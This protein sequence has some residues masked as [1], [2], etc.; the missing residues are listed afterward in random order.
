M[1][2]SIKTKILISLVV[3]SIIL[4]FI[5][6][7]IIRTTATDSVLEIVGGYSTELVRARAAQLGE[8]LLSRQ[9]NAETLAA[10]SDVRTVDWWTM[11]TGLEDELSRKS[12]IYETIFVVRADG[13]A[14]GTEDFLA[15]LED[16]EYFKHI[17]TEKNEKFISNPIESRA[18]GNNVFV[19]AH[20]IKSYTDQI[21]GLI[22]I[23]VKLDAINNV[24]SNIDL[25][26]NSQA[27]VADGT[28]L[29]I[30]HVD[31]SLSMKLNLL[32]SDE[33]GFKGLSEVGRKMLNGESEIAEFF[34]PEGEEYFLIYT[35]IPN[36][37]NWVLGVQIPKAHLMS[38]SNDLTTI[39]TIVTL[40]VLAVMV[41][42]S[43]LIGNSVVKPIKYLS[44]Q[45]NQFGTGDFTVKF[46]SKSKDEIGQMVLALSEMSTKLR[47]SFNVVKNSML[48]L[49][50]SSDELSKLAGDSKKQSDIISKNANTIDGDIQTTASAIEE[51]TSSIEE[52]A[53]SAQNVSKLAQDLTEKAHAVKLSSEEGQMSVNSV[54]DVINQTQTQT[55]ETAKIVSS[56]KSKSENIGK[57]V[58]KINSIAE[59]TNLLA[60]NAAIEAARAGEAGKGFAVVA[61]EIRKLAEESRATTGEIS[62][63]LNEIKKD[64]EEADKATKKTV[65]FVETV[66]SDSFYINESFKNIVEQISQINEMIENLTATSQEQSASS[67]EI[68]GAVDNSA[69]LIHEVMEKVAEMTVSSKKGIESSEQVN[70]MSQDLKMLSEKLTELMNNF[71]V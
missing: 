33:D 70:S 1:F 24:I 8:W 68:A 57:I 10:R 48:D 7:A 3:S 50:D 65:G 51:V 17:V 21:I 47:E 44:G 53:A 52:V 58:D 54:M 63:I 26:E 38:A 23:S 34:S 69:K 2:K 45:I 46:K 41:I 28:G 64:S 14:Q 13:R 19:V 43:I 56:V 5:L 67:E 6:G 59:Q 20:S 31:D 11:R 36:S 29:I 62:G 32:T 39:V 60:L 27:F 42:I 12:G 4:F 66:N 71:K 40:I 16:R 9:E 61:D 37:P 15:Q 55:K 35:P 25:G 18:T 30:S 49:N 22:G